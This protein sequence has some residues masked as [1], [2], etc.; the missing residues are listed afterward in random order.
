LGHALIRE[1]FDFDSKWLIIKSNVD[2]EVVIQQ[3]LVDKKPFFSFYEKRKFNYLKDLVNYVSDETNLN[4]VKTGL[5]ID[6]TKTIDLSKKGSDIAEFVT[7]YSRLLDLKSEVYRLLKINI[8]LKK[9]TIEPGVFVK[10]ARELFL[11]HSHLLVAGLG[12]GVAA[13]ASRY[14]ISPEMLSAI[15]KKFKEIE[16]LERSSEGVKGHH[17][18]ELLLMPPFAVGVPMFL[19]SLGAAIGSMWQQKKYWGTRMTMGERLKKQY[20]GAAIGSL[21]GLGGLGGLAAMIMTPWYSP[22]A[23]TGGAYLGY[24]YFKNREVEKR[25][26]QKLKQE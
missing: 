12:L 3:Y 5:N 2:I 25:R 10:S 20:K 13:L 22:L 7:W 8:P 11:S 24:S 1:I 23:L 4:L 6:E 21:G 19:S 15:D 16:L 26:I 17:F 14:I 9:S 18:I